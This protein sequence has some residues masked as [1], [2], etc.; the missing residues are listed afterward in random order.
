MD[1][2]IIMYKD[3]NRMTIIAQRRGEGTT[4]YDRNVL[5]V[6]EIKLVLNYTVIN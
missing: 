2:L 1:G 4:L 6:T 3:E 5:Y